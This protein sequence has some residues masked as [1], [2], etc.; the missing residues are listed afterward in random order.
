MRAVQI[1]KVSQ[2]YTSEQQYSI[3][4]CC[5]VEEKC[6]VITSVAILYSLY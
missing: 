3:Y 5:V 1:L 6:T 4:L 2:V